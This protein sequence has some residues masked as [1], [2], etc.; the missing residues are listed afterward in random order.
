[1]DIIQVDFEENVI[2]LILEKFVCKSGEENAN[3]QHRV[4]EDKINMTDIVNNNNGRYA[5]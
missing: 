3:G 1:M 4:N 5:M 2:N